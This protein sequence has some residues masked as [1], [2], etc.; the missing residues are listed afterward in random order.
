MNNTSLGMT[1][2]G[3]LNGSSRAR[4]T[5]SSEFNQTIK[6]NQ[7]QPYTG[8][9]NRLSNQTPISNDIKQLARIGVRPKSFKQGIPEKQRSNFDSFNEEQ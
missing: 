5:P 4:Q 9:I 7:N 2:G 3:A 8:E 6:Y 1:G